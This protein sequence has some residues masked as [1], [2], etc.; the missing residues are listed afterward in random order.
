MKNAPGSTHDERK[1]LYSLG[2]ASDSIHGDLVNGKPYWI[3]GWTEV[4]TYPPSG[5]WFDSKYGNWKIGNEGN[6]GK[7][8]GN[9]FSYSADNFFGPHG[10]TKWKYS[11]DGKWNIDNN[12]DIIVIMAGTMFI[13]I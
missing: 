7:T 4:S 11:K 10:V 6:I 5:I 2:S 12:G 1:G 3:K 9:M 8:S 13:K